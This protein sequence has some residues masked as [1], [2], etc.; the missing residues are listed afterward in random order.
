MEE[1]RGAKTGKQMSS[2][3][4]EKVTGGMVAE[5]SVC[6]GTPIED[7]KEIRCCKCQKIFPADQMRYEGGWMCPTCW[8]QYW[9]F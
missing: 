8:N 3:D 1:K 5:G 9:G 6:E 4:L 7:V 2:E